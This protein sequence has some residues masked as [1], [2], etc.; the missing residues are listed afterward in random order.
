MS[1]NLQQSIRELQQLMRK[2]EVAYPAIL[3]LLHFHRSSKQI[4]R[5]EIEGLEVSLKTAAEVSQRA[6][7][8]WKPEVLL[9]ISSL[10]GPPGRSDMAARVPIA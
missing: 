10:S 2:R 7:L 4:D 8:G 5:Q 3:A 1:G 6:N 9:V